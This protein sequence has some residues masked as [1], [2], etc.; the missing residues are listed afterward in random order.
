[1]KKPVHSSNLALRFYIKHG[2]TKEEL[3]ECIVKGNVVIAHP[4]DGPEAYYVL[5]HI[6]CSFDVDKLLEKVSII[7]RAYDDYPDETDKQFIE[8]ML[9]T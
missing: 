7:Y 6:G 1:M 4:K 5:E 3:T 8:R 2:W 9:Y